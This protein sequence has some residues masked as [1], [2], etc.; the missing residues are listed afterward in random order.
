MRYY[1]LFFKPLLT[2]KLLSTALLSALFFSCSHYQH[3]L[4]K[5]STDQLVGGRLGGPETNVFVGGASWGLARRQE[6]FVF[7]VWSP[8]EGQKE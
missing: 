6:A 4:V 7:F 5:I 1:S 3:N 8:E 2:S